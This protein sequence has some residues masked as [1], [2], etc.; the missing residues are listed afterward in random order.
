M[1][2]NDLAP[3]EF[4]LLVFELV[5]NPGLATSPPWARHFTSMR[6]SFPIHRM[7][8]YRI[9]GFITLILL[10]PGVE[11]APVPGTPTAPQMLLFKRRRLS[12]RSWSSKPMPSPGGFVRRGCWREWEGSLSR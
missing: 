6:L 9:Q 4:C 3:G 11:W 12:C 1:G 5:S 8:C 7:G 2:W 10:G